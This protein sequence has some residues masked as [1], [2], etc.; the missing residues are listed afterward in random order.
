MTRF[1]VFVLVGLGAQLVDGSLGM[2]F[3]VTA[4]TLLLTSGVTA[5]VASASVHLAEIGS[6]LVSGVAHWRFQN[7]D[8]KLVVRLGVPGAVGAFVGA[9]LLSRLSTDV[10]APWTSAILL[11]LGVY[12]VLRFATTAI[13]G[14]LA[15]RPPLRKRAL[16]PLGLTAGFID[17]TGGG[18]WGPVATSTL[19]SAKRTEPRKVIGSVSASEFLVA[20]FAS[21]GFLIGLGN[22]AI[23]WA[24]VGGLLAGGV[25]AA[26]LA[27]WLVKHL[28][29]PLLGTG[30]GG[31]L[32]L[33]NV[34]TLFKQTD[35]TAGAR[36]AVYGGIVA[37]VVALGTYAFRRWR[38]DS[39]RLAEESV[40]TVDDR[41]LAELEAA[42]LQGAAPR[43][44]L[45]E[46]GAP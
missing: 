8:W 11:V 5:A 34:R 23:D 33:T 18:G 16:V 1:L 46:G 13:D 26:P 43:S 6:T 38:R 41:E 12:I 7:V 36:F 27:A 3:G 30:A 45:R 22:E 39:A 21:L 10:A 25:V 42:E 2:A 35:L 9:S 19:L 40:E 17:A 31:L 24:V 4:T 14:Q 20:V 32:V 28:P 15:A 37:V 29:V 44:P